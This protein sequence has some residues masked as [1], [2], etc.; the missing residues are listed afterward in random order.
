MSANQHRSA[1]AEDGHVNAPLLDVQGLLVV[2]GGLT[3]VHDFSMK[4][5]AGRI[6]ALIGLNGAG[7]TTTFNCIS[8]YY[9]PTTGRIVF[10]GWMS[11]I[12]GRTRWPH[13]VLP[14]RFRTWS[15]S[16]S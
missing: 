8:R 12:T 10:G 13:S 7:K 6:H 11:L 5:E 4:V 14:G 2:F 1:S 9:Q 15:S 3:A 16:P